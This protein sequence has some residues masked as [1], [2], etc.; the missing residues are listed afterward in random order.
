MAA[1]AVAECLRGMEPA[2]AVQAAARG[3]LLAAFDTKDGSVDDGQRTSRAWLVHTTRVTRGQAAE[4]KAVQAL[5][6]AHRPLL[7]GLRDRAV[8]KSVALQL[9]KWTAGIPG[10]YRAQAEEILVAAARAGAGLR[11]LA[12]ICAE[13]RY[14]PPRPTRTR[15]RG[16]TAGCAWTPPSTGP[17]SCAVISPRN[18]PPWS[19]PSW[20][21]WP[22]RTAAGTRGPGRSATTTP[23]RRRS[24]SGEIAS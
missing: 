18:A 21:R 7:A 24:A 11:E 17:E 1:E 8:T 3:R 5:A 2:D 12:A 23:W 20:T 16:W 19:R 22:P 6:Q 9:A 13:I 4:H 10:E 15:S 14:A